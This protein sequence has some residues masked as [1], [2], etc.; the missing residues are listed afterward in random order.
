MYLYGHMCADIYMHAH[1]CVHRGLHGDLAD[2]QGFKHVLSV[3]ICAGQ[4]HV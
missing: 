3:V 4:R 2:L 1:I